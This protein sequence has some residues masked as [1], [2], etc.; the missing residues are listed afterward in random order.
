MADHI[1]TYSGHSHA[2]S[3]CYSAFR[4]CRESIYTCLAPKYAYGRGLYGY[5]IIYY[6]P[7]MPYVIVKERHETITWDINHESA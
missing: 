5:A 7:Y 1:L 4:D 6:M 3:A 2:G